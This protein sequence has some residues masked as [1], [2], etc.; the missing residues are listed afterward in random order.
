MTNLAPKPKFFKRQSGQIKAVREEVQAILD[1]TRQVVEKVKSDPPPPA[2]SQKGNPE[3][4]TYSMVSG[5]VKDEEVIIDVPRPPA[6]R[7]RLASYPEAP[8]P[9]KK[10]NES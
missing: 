9:R 10:P 1:A 2:L 8:R 6:P 4:G 7:P 5:E 3:A